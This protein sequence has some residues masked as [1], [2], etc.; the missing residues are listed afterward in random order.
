LDKV[1][2]VCRRYD[3]WCH[4][5]AC[6]G[7]PVLLMDEYATYRD[8]LTQADSFSVDLHK[9]FFL[10]LT[11]SL[12]MTRHPVVEADCFQLEASYIPKGEPEPF[13]RGIPTSR[14]ATGLTAWLAIDA[15]GWDFVEVAVRRN[16]H[17]TRLLEHRLREAGLDVL[18]GGDLSVC[19]ARLDND[20]LAPDFHEHVAE[21]VRQQGSAWFGTVQHDGRIWWRFNILNLYADE[22]HV[23]QITALLT[24]EIARMTGE[25]A[26]A[27]S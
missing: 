10:P 24:R 19:C 26:P 8:A 17:L 27:V 2:D 5:D 6:I 9:W 23:V 21:N 4:V 1:I 11:A 20:S 3:L 12:I 15:Y 22:T 16:I 7:G 25:H 14:R 18:P 13:Q